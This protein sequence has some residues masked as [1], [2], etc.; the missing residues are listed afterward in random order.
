MN[1]IRIRHGAA[2][3]AVEL[4]A[5]AGGLGIGL[6]QAGFQP[7]EVVERDRWCCATIRANQVRKID[8]VA[9]WPPPSEVDVRS[10]DY[11]KY[12]GQIDLISGGPPCQ[13]FSL[14][15]KHRAND[16]E[17]D[18]WSEAVRAVRET[19]PPA[20]IFENV[21]GLT[22]ETFAAYLSY[23]TLQLSYPDVAPRNDEGS[24]RIRC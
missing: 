16:D 17:R 11:S 22:R 15:G 1:K 24:V 13:P 21:K 2:M 18:M 19:C 14:G 3:R 20:F 5:G 7:V 6:S 10:L 9:S 23:I 12:N 8:A 4:F